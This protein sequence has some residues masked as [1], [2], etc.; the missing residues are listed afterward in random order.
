[1]SSSSYET[2]ESSTLPAIGSQTHQ[3]HQ[4]AL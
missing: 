2:A 1:M 3:I 4:R